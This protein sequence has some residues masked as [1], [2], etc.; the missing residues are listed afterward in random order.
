MNYRIIANILGRVM[1]IEALLMIPPIAT[2]L[3]YRESITCFLLTMLIAAALA[4]LLSRLKPK[5][6][7]LYAREGFVSVA[8]SWILMS[9]VGAL[10][11]FFSGEIP[12]YVDAVFETVSGFTTTGASIITNLDVISHGILFWRSLSQ[13]IGGMGV[14][15]FIMAVLP[16]SEEHSMHIMRAEVPGPQV[17]KLVPRVRTSSA[18]TYLIYVGLTALLIILL[19]MGG[20]PVFDSFI[21]AMSAASTG[22]YGVK[23]LSIGYYDS[24]YIDVVTSIFMLLFGINFSIYFLLLMKKFRKVFTNSELLCYL[25][26][27]AFSTVTIAIDISRIY[28]TIGSSLRFSFFQVSSIM[29]T[30]GFATADFEQWP[31]YSK[32]LLII[33]MFIGACS[34]STGGGIK[35]SRLIILI[36][37]TFGEFFR[38]INPRKI[39]S[40]TVDDQEIDSSTIRSTQV[41]F[42]LYMSITFVSCLIVSLDGFDFTT[43][44]SAVTACISNIGPGLGLVSPAG[45]YAFFSGFSKIVLSLCMLIGRLEVFPMLMLAIPSVW[46]RKA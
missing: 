33:L 16:L 44:F 29:T 26:I 17:G 19:C 27:V 2:A 10:P 43:N 6:K 15:V 42:A 34:G 41:F 46:R 31:S 1:T 39:T 25:G 7:D 11:F 30:T 40:V 23:G 13:W 4:V 24:A 3:I 12:N 14:L 36:K 21:H 28:G 18:I 37:S 9:L 38:L 20:M 22:G 45:N 5:R 8:L 32:F 35:V